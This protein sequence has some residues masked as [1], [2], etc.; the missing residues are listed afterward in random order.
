MTAYTEAHLYKA[1]SLISNHPEFYTEFLRDVSFWSSH[2]PNFIMPA[3]VMALNY[4]LL[5][6]SRH[7]FLVN[8][9]QHWS[10]FGKAVCVLYGSGVAMVLPQT[11]LISYLTFGLTHLVVTRLLKAAQGKSESEFDAY[12]RGK[13]LL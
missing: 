6:N 3:L 7:P 13:G 12:L 9:R 10:P 1:L 11:Y 2:D 4:A 8:V 5:Q